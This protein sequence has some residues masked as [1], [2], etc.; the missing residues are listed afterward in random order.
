MAKNKKKKNRKLVKK[1]E[2][3]FC[4]DPSLD[5]DYK[6]VE[7]LQRY[8]NDKAKIVTRRSSGACA[9]HQR[10]LAKAIK[11][12]RILALLPFVKR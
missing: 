2:C 7:L 10:K 5:I 1:K 4:K 9:K 3:P 11:N 8:I 6:N 12:A